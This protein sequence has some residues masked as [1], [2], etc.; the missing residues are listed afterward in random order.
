MEEKT[1]K[2]IVI[3]LG[4]NALQR[5]GEAGAAAQQKIADQT[6]RQ[7]APL[8]KDG[9]QIVIVHGNGPQVGNIVIH[10]EAVNTADVPTLPLDTCVAMSEGSIGYWLQQALT[11]ELRKDGLE[12]TV[13]TLVTQMLVDENDPGFK[14]PTKPIGPFYETE[15]IARQQAEKRGFVVKEDAGRGWRRVVP[16]PE[17]IEAVEKGAISQLI[18]EG[19]IVIAAGGGGVP[20]VMN[21]D[22]GLKGVEAVI[23]KDFS[24][25]VVADLIDA[26][27]L[28]ILTGV[29]G[30]MLNFGQADQQPIGRTSVAAMGEYV[31]QGQFAPGSMLPKVQ[32][33]IKFVNKPGRT[34][35]IASLD[36]VTGAI[37]ETSGT[38]IHS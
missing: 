21:D 1:Q 2:R 32:A 35:T 13:V 16:S 29:G 26:D 17:P 15:E 4:G 18:N 24:A 14:D 8:V 37:A 33:A 23:D 34:A 19:T 20:V 30:A 27:R 36:D 31:S 9:Y 28:I 10:E 5:K 3:A 38:I 7:L 11:D 25:A 12:N 6:A 22:E